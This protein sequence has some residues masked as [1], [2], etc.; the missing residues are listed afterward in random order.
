MSDLTK[1]EAISTLEM[2]RYPEPW[3]PKLSKRAEEALD[4]AIADLSTIEKIR[5]EILALND[6]YC[7]TQEVLDIIDKHIGR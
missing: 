3:E 7:S 4:M 6:D 5:A 2:L 1:E